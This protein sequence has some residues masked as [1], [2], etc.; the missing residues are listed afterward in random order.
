MT[1]SLGASL[2]SGAEGSA[3]A[4]GPLGAE[5]KVLGVAAGLLVALLAPACAPAREHKFE[6]R[7]MGTTYH[8]TVVARGGVSGLQE[9]IDRRLEEI[10]RSL[11]TYRPESEISRFNRFQGV[12]EEFH[13][14]SDFL[15]VMKAGARVFGLS[16]GAWDGT[17]RPLVDLWGFG[18]AGP[19]RVPPAPE[20]VAA[21]LAD[22][23]FQ[24]IEIRE[25]G[26]LV[27][28]QA[29]VTLDLSSIAPGYG[30]DEVA[31][32]IRQEGFSQFLVEIGGEVRAGGS[33]LDG[34]AWRV[35]IGRPRVD[36]APDE[37]YR[38]APL[39]DAA[40]STSGDYRNYFVRDGVR[41]SHILDPRTGRPV[42]NG[43]VSVVHPRPGLHAGGR[44]LHRRHGHGCRGGPCARGAPRGRGGTDRRGDAGRAARGPPVERLPLRAPARVGARPPTRSSAGSAPARRPGPPA[45][46]SRPPRSGSR[47][48]RR[49]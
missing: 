41:Y 42:A 13:V 40:F 27:K 8:V 49:R 31:D 28:R 11:S 34:R 3:R 26:A 25:K 33:R 1:S 2:V 35:G 39:R 6:G 5:R 23:G 36:A 24:K 4:A 43:V 10:E 16:G 21:R 12:G 19:V 46:C 38:V 17:V 22:V 30:V 48:S 29:S 7:T 44:A 15:R 47:T 32:L 9:R 14:S 20:V 45:R 18:P 37:V